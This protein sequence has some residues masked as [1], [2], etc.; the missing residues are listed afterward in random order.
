[1]REPNSRLKHEAPFEHG[2]ILDTRPGAGKATCLAP[3][4][5]V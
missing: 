5:A 4:K 1:M 3:D 2:G